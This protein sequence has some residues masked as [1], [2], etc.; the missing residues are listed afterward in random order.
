MVLNMN[1]KDLKYHSA[2]MLSRVSFH[3][4]RQLWQLIKYT[5]EKRVPGT[6]SQNMQL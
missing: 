2:F 5:V 6:G 4:K 1:Y 3:G